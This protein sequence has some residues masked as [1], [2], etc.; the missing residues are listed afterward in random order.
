MTSHVR[1]FFTN[2]ILDIDRYELLR[3]GEVV[4]V[5]PQV[6]D[7][8]SLLARNPGRLITKEELQEEIWGGRIVS[9]SAISAR[10]SD[11]SSSC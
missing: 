2:C 7:L 10:S 4:E 3:D 9:D 5:E 11:S 1:I 8:I 6:F